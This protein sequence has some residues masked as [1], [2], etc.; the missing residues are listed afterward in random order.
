M[1]R[2]EPWSS[3]SLDQDLNAAKN[4]AKLSGS[5]PDSQNPCGEESAGR[6]REALVNLS[7]VTQE[8]DA[9]DASA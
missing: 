4:L 7:S 8:S 5:S 3:L 2:Q 6:D 9:F 1:D